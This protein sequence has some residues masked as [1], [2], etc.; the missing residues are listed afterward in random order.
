M[1][2]RRWV[3]ARGWS[4]Q[5]F[6][7]LGEALVKR[8]LIQQV[9]GMSRE[10]LFLRSPL[11]P[12]Q[13]DCD[14]GGPTTFLLRMPQRCPAAWPYILR[15]L[16]CLSPSWPCIKTWISTSRLIDQRRR[17]CRVGRT[18]SRGRQGSPE[19]SARAPGLLRPRTPRPS[20]RAEPERCGLTKRPDARRRVAGAQGSEPTDQPSPRP[21]HRS[22]SNSDAGTQ[23]GPQGTCPRNP[24]PQLGVVGISPRPP[25]GWQGQG[26]GVSPRAPLSEAAGRARG[27]PQLQVL[28]LH[29][30]F[31]QRLDCC[32]EPC[33]PLPTP[34]SRHHPWECGLRIEGSSFWGTGT[35]DPDP[36]VA[37]CGAPGE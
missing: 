32:W 12:Y 31:C 37:V 20:Q 22:S 34:S 29:F 16:S 18:A 17:G 7:S 6:T 25:G 26:L 10:S 36:R 8:T 1:Q 9:W 11:L 5:N 35:K 30:P 14:L 28:P 24:A 33:S 15:P 4:V 13:G 2:R 23:A 21:R 19:A 27:D 3:H